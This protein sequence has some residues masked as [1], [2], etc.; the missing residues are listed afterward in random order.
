MPEHPVHVGG[1]PVAGSRGVEHQH[2]PLRA[3]E[4]EGSAEARC[5]AANHDHIPRGGGADGRVR[6]GASVLTAFHTT[7][8]RARMG[9]WQADLQFQQTAAVGSDDRSAHR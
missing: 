4:G 6:G 5:S 1:E 8:V 9:P 3:G 2:A 7:S